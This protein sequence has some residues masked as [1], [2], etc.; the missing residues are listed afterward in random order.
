MPLGK[1]CW[2]KQG[3]KCRWKRVLGEAGIRNVLLWMAGGEGGWDG[4]DK[5]WLWL[6]DPWCACSN[7]AA[8]SQPGDPCPR[9]GTGGLELCS[10]G[11][12]FQPLPRSTA[13][14]DPV[15]LILPGAG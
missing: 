14:L 10:P 12:E 8:L 1:G 11:E 9:Q 7:R 3:G 2:G 5:A 15:H 13:V 4:K 6:L